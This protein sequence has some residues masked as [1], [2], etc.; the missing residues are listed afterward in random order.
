MFP[1]EIPSECAANLYYIEHRGCHCS[2]P[3]ARAVDL[4]KAVAA[5]V[6]DEV[7]IGPVDRVSGVLR[8]IGETED[9]GAS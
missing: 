1:D 3:D 7:R 2:R 4:V 8:V 9:G 5:R 6:G